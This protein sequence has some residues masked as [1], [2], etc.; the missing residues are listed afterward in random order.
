VVI[1][2]MGGRRRLPRGFVHPVISLVPGI[3]AFEQQ[4]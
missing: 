1:L 4:R 3:I 2:L